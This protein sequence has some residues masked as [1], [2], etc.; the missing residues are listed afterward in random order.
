MNNE[1]YS[2]KRAL[3]RASDTARSFMLRQTDN[4][5]RYVDAKEGSELYYFHANAAN[6]LTFE[7]RLNAAYSVFPEL[8]QRTEFAR[9][10]AEVQKCYDTVVELAAGEKARIADKRASVAAKRDLK[11]EL[12][13]QEGVSLK[14]VDVGQYK[15]ILA[16]LEPVRIHALA[17]YRKQISGARTEQ[18]KLLNAH[19]G[20]VEQVAEW[21]TGGSERHGKYIE[22]PEHFAHFFEMFSGYGEPR[23][24]RSQPAGKVAKYIEDQAQQ[25]ALAY[26]QG[27]AAK[28][29][30][31]TGEEIAN[32]PA[33]AGFEPRTVTVSSSNLW[34]DSI[35]VIR[36]N[37]AAKQWAELRFHTQMIWNRSC[38]GLEFNQ[39]PTRRID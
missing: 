34:S 32:D 6:R 27:Y 18:A 23:T 9:A 7:R 14:G 36:M 31:K 5:Q 4:G 13:L 20:N 22:F 29:S 37:N 33:L 1:L 24:F 39:W 11:A 15:V 19:A 38:L 28:L 12:N 17:A 35:A 21:R 2:A 8:V 3:D 10:V 30:V 16:G 25:K 26:V